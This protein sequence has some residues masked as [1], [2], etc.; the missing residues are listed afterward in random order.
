MAW[1]FVR[2]LLKK[3]EQ[4]E[5]LERNHL[6]N[7]RQGMKT[8]PIAMWEAHPW[9]RRNGGTPVGFSWQ[10]SVGNEQCDDVY[11]WC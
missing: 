5:Q 4:R 1:N 3:K 8:R 7:K 9:E 11:T 6:E 2:D 10:I